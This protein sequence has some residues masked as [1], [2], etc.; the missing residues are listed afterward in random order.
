MFPTANGGVHTGRDNNTTT[1]YKSLIE[2][3]AMFK[4]LRPPKRFDPTFKRADNIDWM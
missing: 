2:S 4:G 1:T 3:K